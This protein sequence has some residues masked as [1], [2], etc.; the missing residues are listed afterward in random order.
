[1]TQSRGGKPVAPLLGKYSRY[2]GG[3]TSFTHLPLIWYVVAN[4]YA[5]VPRF[6]P[7]SPL[8]TELEMTWLVNSDAVAGRDFDP[9]EVCW[10]WTVTAEQDKLLC[11]N[12]QRGILSS[13]YRPGPYVAAEKAV[14]DF[15]TWY[16]GE[17]AFQGH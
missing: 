9:E 15:V 17:I 13:R 14:D 3:I 5:F 11:E 12:T 10:L 6:T 7:I 2:D 4:D 8:E 16:L 1:M